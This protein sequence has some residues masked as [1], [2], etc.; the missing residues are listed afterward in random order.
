[1]GYYKELD[2]ERIHQEWAED[3]L[4]ASLQ[5]ILDKELL[6]VREPRKSLEELLKIEK[7]EVRPESQYN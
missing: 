1:M 4:L 7:Y 5:P 6:E 3:A 2:I